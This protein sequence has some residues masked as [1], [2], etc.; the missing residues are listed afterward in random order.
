MAKSFWDAFSQQKPFQLKTAI[1][2]QR[3]LS[4]IL[5]KTHKKTSS[6]LGAQ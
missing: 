5:N 6:T 2:A 1:V 3:H 4:S